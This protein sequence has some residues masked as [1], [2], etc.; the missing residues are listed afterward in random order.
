MTAER[1]IEP[2]KIWFGSTQWHPQEQWFLKAM[3]L[4]KNFERDFAL[5]D[6]SNF[7]KSG[8]VTPKIDVVIEP[9]K[10]AALTEAKLFTDGGSRGNPG[11]SAIGYVLLDMEDNV[12]K[13]ESAYLGV[14]TN[15]QAEYQ[16]LKAGLEDALNRGV[17]KLEAYLDSMLV[18]NQVNGTWKMKNQELVPHHQAIQQLVLRFEKVTFS[19]VPRAMNALADAMVNECLDKQ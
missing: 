19:H 6:I 4:D 15:N 12:V 9:D 10:P 17:K 5:L 8:M 18:V 3:D 1:T 2:I 7:D 16:A 11:P 14:T 13:K